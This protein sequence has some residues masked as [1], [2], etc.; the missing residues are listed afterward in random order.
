MVEVSQGRSGQSGLKWLNRGESDK[1]RVVIRVIVVS[2]DGRG[3]VGMKV[4]KSWW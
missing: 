4:V 2:Q 1:V 3:K